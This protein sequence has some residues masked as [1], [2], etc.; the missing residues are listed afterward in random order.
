MI[1]GKSALL[2]AVK[3]LL[4]SIIALEMAGRMLGYLRDRQECLSY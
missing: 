1:N 4:A 2:A 3:H